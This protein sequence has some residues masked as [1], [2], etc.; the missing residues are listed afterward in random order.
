V[1]TLVLALLFTLVALL[2]GGA[3]WRGVRA[4]WAAY[5]RHGRVLRRLL[6]DL[7]VKSHVKPL[8]QP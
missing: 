1:A 3:P 8:E 6:E 5:E 2:T 4:D 7:S